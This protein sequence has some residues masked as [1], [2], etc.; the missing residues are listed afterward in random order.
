MSVHTYTTCRRSS[1]LNCF[2]IFSILLFLSIPLRHTSLS[3]S[4]PP[5]LT[6]P[7]PPLIYPYPL[8]PSLKATSKDP[9]PPEAAT[10]ASE[11]VTFWQYTWD[12]NTNHH[13]YW[14]PGTNEVLWDL[15]PG[16]VE[17]PQ[18]AEVEE[19]K[20][21]AVKEVEELMENYPYLKKPLPE[22]KPGESIT[23]E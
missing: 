15:P 6:H 8:L 17:L 20:E 11:N 21:D 1:D 18:T 12:Y 22:V 14:N 13:Y 3:L 23:C 4:P 19:G 2:I 16:G 10:A 7:S 5:S 9:P